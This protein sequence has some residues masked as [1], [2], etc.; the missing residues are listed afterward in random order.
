MKKKTE[1]ATNVS[2]GAEK[3]QKIEKEIKK[4]TVSATAP[5]KEVLVKKKET[6]S[7]KKPVGKAE[8][9]SEAAKARVEKALKKK[10]AAEQKKE[11]RLKKMEK[12]KAEIEKLRKKRLEERKAREE[13]KKQIREE[14]IRERAHAKANKRQ[15]KNHAKAKK[16]ENKKG[17]RKGYGGWLAAVISLSAVTLA[18]ATALTLGAIDMSKTKKGAISGYKATMYELTSVME[19]V[20]NDLDRARLSASPAQQS[21]ILTDLLVQARV[22]ETDLEKMPIKMEEDQNLTAFLNRTAAESERML[23]KLR[24]GESLSEEDYETLE[25]LYQTNHTIL[26]DWSE[27][28]RTI[29]DKDMTKFLKKGEGM[30]SETMRRIENATLEENG[31]MLHREMKGEKKAPEAKAVES[32]IDSLRAEELCRNYFSEYAIKE[33]Q[34]VGQTMARGYSAYNV[35]GYD[36]KGTMLYAEI[37]EKSGALIGFDYHEDCETEHFDRGNSEKIAT[38]FLEKLGYD[39]MTVTRVSE[40]GTNSDFTF[41]YE[42]DGVAFYPDSVHVKVCRSRGV[43]TGFDAR[44]FLKNH[45]TRVEP[46]VR[47]SMSEAREKLREGLSVEAS[48]LAVIRAGGKERAAYEFL[49]DYQGEKYFIFTDANSGEELSIVNVNKLG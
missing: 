21:R 30:F 44:A 12:R 11:E 42:T 40:S 32:S 5:E 23:S 45:T 48:K 20:E 16:S 41:V 1:T 33:F 37:D 27:M 2:S 4:E 29:S 46:N 24:H 39:N 18:L 28:M 25:R 13:K 19:N 31:K 3:V 17:E 43:V 10:K 36:E 15:A 38:Q 34:C 14:R 26:Q 47:L 22:A 7:T 9:E 8:K 49:C 35:Q 6:L